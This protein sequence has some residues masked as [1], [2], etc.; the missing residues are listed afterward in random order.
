MKLTGFLL[1]PDDKPLENGSVIITDQ[2]GKPLGPGTKT[3]DKGFFSIDDPLLA[4]SDVRLQFSY[5]GLRPVRLT[6]NEVD[7]AM[8]IYL[9]ESPTGLAPVAVVAKVKKKKPKVDY[10][11]VWVFGSLAVVMGLW[12]A[13]K[14]FS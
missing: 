9:E 5:A 12:G 11:L 1:G 6:A 10:T 8:Y 14:K 13:Y 2:D 3:D 4:R 7:E